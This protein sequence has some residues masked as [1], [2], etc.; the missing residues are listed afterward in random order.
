MRQAAPDVWAL[1]ATP[2]PHT[3]LIQTNG[4]WVLI[5]AGYP[6]QARR[7]LREVQ[8][9]TNPLDGILLT[10]HDLDHIGALSL[11]QREMGTP[12]YVHAADL[13]FF[14]GA[15]KEPARKNA[16]SKLGRILTR[17]PRDLRPLDEMP[18]AEITAVWTPGHT[19]GHTI[20]RYGDLVFTGDMFFNHA[21][22]GL[23]NLWQYHGDYKAAASSLRNVAAMREVT[24][25]PAHGEPL[26]ATETAAAELQALADSLDA[27]AKGP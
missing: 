15:R 19:P 26:R 2:N 6:W 4:R 9:K 22:R 13:P 21:G 11:L 10:H 23:E 24:F 18:F 8:E 16:L 17:P 3:F 27:A 12:V 25:L 7:V 20:Y 5:D 1:E 14:D